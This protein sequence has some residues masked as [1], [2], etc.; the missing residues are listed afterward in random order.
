MT[1]L[2]H[3]TSEHLTH[4]KYRPDIDG[5]RAISILLVVAFHAFPSLM[6][7]GFIGVDIFFVISGYLIS[8]I[9]IGNLEH[10]SFSFI[11]FYIRRIKRIFPALLLVLISCLVVGYFSLLNSEY[12][13]LGKHIAGGAGFISNYILWNESGYFDNSALSKPLLHLWS[14]GVEEQFYIVWPLLMWG[15]W[16]LRLNLL[17]IAITIGCIS[18]ALNISKVGSD[19]VAAFYSPQT[20]FWELMSGSVLAYLTLHRLNTFPKCIHWIGSRFGIPN[21]TLTPDTN[22]AALRNTQS[23]IGV[24]LIAIGTSITEKNVFPGWWAL[25]PI[26]G[27]ILIISAG[28]QA[29]FNRVILSNRTLVWVGL[30]S[31]PL[32]LWHWPLLS[33][34]HILLGDATSWHIRGLAVIVSFVLA[35][36]TY[37]LIEAPIRL[38]KHGRT[39]VIT[40]LIL[41]TCVGY[42]GYNIFSRDGLTYRYKSWNTNVQDYDWG[43]KNAE[44]ICHNSFPDLL[45]LSFCSATKIG[46]PTILYLGDSHARYSYPGIAEGLTESKEN[47]VNFGEPGCLAFFDVAAPSYGAKDVCADKVNR[48]L[49][50]A[51]QQESV[52]TV[53]LHNFGSYYLTRMTLHYG[54]DKHVLLKSNKSD[55]LEIEP[56][57]LTTQPELSDSNI[58]FKTAMKN[59]IKRLLARNIKI[60]YMLDAPE[61]GFI[62]SSVC[63]NYGLKITRSLKTPCAIPRW[64]HEER[65]RQYRELVFSVLKDFPSVRVFD[66]ASLMCD[67]QWC[68][69]MKDGKLLYVDS[70]HLSAEGSRLFAKELAQLLNTEG[71]KTSSVSK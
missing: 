35:W 18:F 14:L 10:S 22:E 30:I 15:A 53:I 2:P 42:T 46:A 31:F 70:S 47:I 1:L 19:T 3:H 26:L 17:A 9:I 5:L 6:Q 33:F 36:I 50:F 20:R 34:V 27:A 62:P 61:M 38:G 59:T 7:A 56:I 66:P 63:T 12:K 29:W 39:K 54:A 69:G 49:K 23:I 51:E 58:V 43:W 16:K 4:P 67:A 25:F 64:V 11:E 68:W 40:L 44:S 45:P 60:I 55:Q 52:H 13:Q 57:Y 32:Y 21:N 8:T 65:T 37:K 24:L 48:Y 28:T 41:M 71:M